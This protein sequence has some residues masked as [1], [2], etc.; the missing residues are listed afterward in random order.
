M[1]SYNGGVALG[2]TPDDYQGYGRVDLVN[3]LPLEKCPYSLFVR[4]AGIEQLQGHGLVVTISDSAVPLK[5]TMRVY[6]PCCPSSWILGDVTLTV[7]CH[8]M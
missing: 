8:A 7:S 3:A 4:E 1:S 2:S 6:L 5:V